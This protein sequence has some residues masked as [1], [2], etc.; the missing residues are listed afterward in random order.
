VRDISTVG[1]VLSGIH[2]ELILLSRMNAENEKLT[3]T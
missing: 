1:V 3:C 2:Y